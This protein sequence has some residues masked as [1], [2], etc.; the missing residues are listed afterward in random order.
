MAKG[1]IR[2]ILK[3]KEIEEGKDADLEKGD[4]LALL[5]A[6]ASVFLPIVLLMLAV[7]FVIIK[8]LGW[9]F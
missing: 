1:K 2:E 9:I 3:K 5:I 4:F 6:A 8:I 7:F